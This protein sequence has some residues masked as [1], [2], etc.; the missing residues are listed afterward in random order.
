MSSGLVSLR[1]SSTFSPAC[2]RSTAS[3]AVKASLPT[4]RRARRAGRSRRTSAA[5][6]ATVVKLGSRSCV[7]SPAG[8]RTTA[9]FSRDQLLLDHVAGDLDGR[10]AGPLAGPRLQHEQ[11]PLLDRELD[12]LHVAVVLF[13]RLLDFEQLL[14]D[15]PVPLRHL[16]DRLRRADAGHHVFA[17]GV[18]EKLAVELVLAGRRIA[19]E[20]H[21]RPESSPMLP[22]TIDWTLTAVPNRPV[23]FSTWRY[24][25]ARVCIQLLNTASIGEFELLRSGPA[26]RAC[27]GASGRPSCTRRRAS[28][29]PFGRDVGVGSAPY[30]FLILSKA[31]SKCSWSTPKTTSPYMLISRR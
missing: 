28:I 5:F 24:L 13:E 20:R 14:V 22:K 10:G 25:T 23:M 7:R 15:L 11:R 21:A 9:S 31:A 16:G 6:L 2:V 3:A 26:G 1:T 30:F 29:M 12:V 4:P 18:D 17:L 19:R 8:T 27:R